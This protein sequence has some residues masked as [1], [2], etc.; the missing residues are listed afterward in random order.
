MAAAQPFISI[1]ICTLNGAER[2]VPALRSL[3]KQDYA[4]RRYEI[5]V[6][7]DG[8][9]DQLKKS[10]AAY[11]FKRLTIV[12]HEYNR[13]IGAARNTGLQ[14]ARGDIV[15]YIDDDCTA[16]R[17]WLKALAKAFDD[18]SAQAVGGRLQQGRQTSWAQRYIYEAGRGLPTLLVGSRSFASRFTSYITTKYRPFEAYKKRRAVAEIYTYNAA[19]RR[20]A[21]QA[22]GGFDEQLGSHEDVDVSRRLNALYGDGAIVFDPHP[23]VQHDNDSSFG[24]FLRKAFRRQKHQV[25]VAAKAAASP[26]LF[27]FPFAVM[28]L[29]AGAA[30]QPWLLLAAA[31]SPLA[32]YNWWVYRAVR[33]RKLRHLAHAYMNFIE[34]SV[35]TAG[36]LAAY[37]RRGAGTRRFEPIPPDVYGPPVLVLAALLVLRHNVYVHLPLAAALLLVPGYLVLRIAGVGDRQPWLRVALAAAAGTAWTMAVGLAATS[38]LPLA[39]VHQP[40]REVPLLGVYAASLAVT[41]W[42]AARRPRVRLVRWRFSIANR[43]AAALYG[44]AILLPILSFV[45]ASLLNNGYDNSW[46]VVMFLLAGVAL[47]A[48]TLRSNRLPRSVLP[49]LLFSI[50]LSAVWTYSLRS[51]AVFGWDIQQEL[52]VFQHTQAAGV[53]HLGQTHTQYDAMLSLT[54][55]PTVLANLAGLSGGVIFKV[56]MPLLFS[57]LPVLL[58]YAYRQFAKRW[59]AFVAAALVVAQFYYLQEFSALVRQQVGFVYFALLLFAL[60]HKTWSARTKK[61][62]AGLAI[63]G[64]IVSHYSTA[65]ATIAVLVIVYVLAKI[66]L[67][68]WRMVWFNELAAREVLVKTWVVLA[69]LIGSVL[70]YGPATHSDVVANSLFRPRAYVQ[71]YQATGAFLRRSVVLSLHFGS[72]GQQKQQPSAAHYLSTVG[73]E[74]QASKPYFSYYPGASNLSLAA[75]RVPEIAH[76]GALYSLARAGD[77]ALRSG[78]WL[79]A[80]VGIGAMAWAVYRRFDER[81]MEVTLLV[82]VGGLLFIAA[83]IVPAVARLY[84]VSRIVEQVL[85]LAALPAVMTAAWLLKKMLPALQKA[86]LAMVIAI[87][88]LYAAG[89]VTQATGGPAAANLNNYGSDYQQYY[90]TS[91]DLA[92]AQWLGTQ[93]RA[94]DVLYADRYAALRFTTTIPAQHGIFTDVSP[95]TVARNAYVYA[96]G[97]NVL[98]GVAIANDGGKTVMYQF[99]AAFLA[100]HKNILY[101]NGSAEIYR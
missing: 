9:S 48:A 95:E 89:L 5:I 81:H 38:L 70:W 27:P 8:G 36:L 73:A 12:R 25:G 11:K 77:T 58:Y 68:V 57:L 72:G 56:G 64:L 80:F 30:W 67:L 34:E 20:A 62:L 52:S 50:S 92:A 75:V 29:I 79:L 46:L 66:L 100:A 91:T 54:V 82:G 40:L 31:L 10:L 41:A 71:A 6:V 39:G 59:L 84:N 4:D 88:L 43:L 86:A 33:E 21:L 85:L 2:I 16:A 78:W 55:L 24:L 76:R 17:G 23:A 19:Y 1:V 13:G 47:V 51:G 61:W 63:W 42:A 96:D 18:D 74:F 28:A 87:S 7:D 44:V 3:Q 53:W 32:L 83:H 94:G 69:L 65:Y 35:L 98:Q 14:A 93:Y 37:V 99:P 60:L 22:I 101:S 90:M 97:T 26:P 45:G 15:A 49:A